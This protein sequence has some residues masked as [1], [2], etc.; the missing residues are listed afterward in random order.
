MSKERRTYN[1]DT[2]WC[3]R[4]ARST[5]CIEWNCERTTALPSRATSDHA[6]AF[7]SPL[8]NFEVLYI[9]YDHAFAD[10]INQMIEIGRSIETIIRPV[11]VHLRCNYALSLLS[12]CAAVTHCLTP[13]AAH[14]WGVVSGHKSTPRTRRAHPFMN[15]HETVRPL[16]ER[17]K[18][19]RIIQLSDRRRFIK[20]WHFVVNS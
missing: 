6:Q 19:L 2:F 18:R 5:I 16:A 9:L 13:Y 1:I 10:G 20:V 12:T 4:G 3:R 8:Y 7:F 15:I 14:A 17:F 11:R